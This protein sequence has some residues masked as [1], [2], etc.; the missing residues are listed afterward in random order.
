[1][2][3]NILETKISQLLGQ[4]YFKKSVLVRFL[5][6]LI[7]LIIWIS[8]NGGLLPGFLRQR[9]PILRV[10]PELNILYY[11]E[12]AERDG[13]KIRWSRATN[14]PAKLK[15]ALNGKYDM[16]EADVILKG[17]GTSKQAMTPIVSDLPAVD[18]NFELRTWLQQVKKYTKGIKLDFRTI[19]AVEMSLQLLKSMKDELKIPI[20]LHADILKG[21][22]SSRLPVDATRF[23]RNVRT[24]F[25]TCTLSL[26][27]T[28][29]YHTDVSQAGYTWDMVLDMHDLIIHWEISQPLVFSVRLAYIKNSIPQLKWLCD[30]LQASLLVWNDN[31]DKPVL[32]DVMYVAYRFP[33]EKAFFDFRD[34]YL[35]SHLKRYR[36]F[37]KN[38]VHPLV[39]ER[40]QVKFNP[41]AWV[42]MGL[43]IEENSILPSSESL[44]LKSP[45]VY[46]VSISKLKSVETLHLKGRVHFLNRKNQ[47]ANNGQTGLSIFFR[48]FSYSDYEKISGIRFFIGVNGDLQISGQHLGKNVP[49]FKKRAR[50]TPGSAS[51][52]RFDIVDLRHEVVMEINSLHDCDTLESVQHE[53]TSHISLRVNIPNEL[54]LGEQPYILK[55]EDNRRVAVID[56]L[57]IRTIYQ[58][59]KKKNMNSI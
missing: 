36:H 18:N 16:I 10:G 25:P 40:D 51:C 55:M 1:M 41:Y 49:E 22:Y 5:L 3:T 2:A 50:V 19:D 35:S 46:I 48:S 37:S 44:V 33:P 26:G 54:A 15:A 6:F 8:V 27:W 45:A 52:Y 47:E 28:T 42:K 56:E 7:L 14:T 13:S 4:R 58:T 57:D 43:Y 53:D 21:P 23:F 12:E 17:Q 30:T 59:K 29:G 9:L 39:L 31:E 34:E 24:F 32:E 20:W 38:Y 11:F